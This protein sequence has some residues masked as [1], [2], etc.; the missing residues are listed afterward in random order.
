MHAARRTELQK[1]VVRQPRMPMVVIIVSASRDTACCTSGS[2]THS[3]Y[4]L[5]DDDIQR[6][7]GASSGF[8][9]EYRGRVRGDADSTI[10]ILWLVLIACKLRVYLNAWGD[11]HRHCNRRE[12]HARN[13]PGFASIMYNLRTTITDH[14]GEGL[15]HQ[16]SPRLH[17]WIASSVAALSS[18]TSASSAWWW[19]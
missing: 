14:H 6:I 19:G 12:R 2:V 13:E 4:G 10:A 18:S 8:L 1:P 17:C 15:F 16:G 9:T 3:S 7:T 5:S 11:S